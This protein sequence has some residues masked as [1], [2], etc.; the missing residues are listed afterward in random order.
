MIIRVYQLFNHP[1]VSDLINEEDELVL[2]YLDT[3]SV[4]E[5]E[6]VKSGFKILM[7]SD[8]RYAYMYDCMLEFVFLC[9]NLLFV[10]Q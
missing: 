6:N 9:T 3:L 2:Q 7:V 8:H 1:G 4:D 10:H 5:Y